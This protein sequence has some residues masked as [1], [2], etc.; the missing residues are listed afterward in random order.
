M[1]SDYVLCERETGFRNTIDTNFS[2]QR[3]TVGASYVIL[4]AHFK[5]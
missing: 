1:G 2:L 4:R 3:Q 5:P